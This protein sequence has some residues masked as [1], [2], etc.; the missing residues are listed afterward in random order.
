MHSLN[1]LEAVQLGIF[2]FILQFLQDQL[3]MFYKPEPNLEQE[4]FTIYLSIYLPMR[5]CSHLIKVRISAESFKRRWFVVVARPFQS[6]LLFW[7]T[8]PNE[9]CLAWFTINPHLSNITASLH[10]RFQFLLWCINFWSVTTFS[11]CL[12]LHDKNTSGEMYSPCANLNRF[13]F[14][15]M[16]FNV[17]SLVHIPIGKREKKRERE[18][19]REKRERD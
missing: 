1:E 8:D 19:E 6:C 2:R 13:F 17:P 5:G 14:L 15:S 9:T 4:S 7:N 12:S 18:R 3:H 16:I 11:K 10:C